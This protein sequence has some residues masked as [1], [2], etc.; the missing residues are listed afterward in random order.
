M[1]RKCG[2]P[3]SLFSSVGGRPD[4]EAGS[5]KRYEF[6][7]LHDVNFSF[8]RPQT[9]GSVADRDGHGAAF[10]AIIAEHKL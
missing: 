9:Q 10:A 8:P 2:V 7:S 1:G 3:D 5:V 6:P 4:S